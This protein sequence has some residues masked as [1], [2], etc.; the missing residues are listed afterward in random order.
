MKKENNI[1]KRLKTTKRDWIVF[2]ISALIAVFSVFYL[3]YFT[4]ILSEISHYLD[5]G[6]KTVIIFAWGVA[7]NRTAVLLLSV[8]SR[9]DKRTETIHLMFVSFIKYLIAII[10]IIILL[11]VWLGEEYV[12][13]IL[14]GIGVLALIIGLG[15]QSLINDILAGLFLVF[16]NHIN[17]GDV[18]SI[19]SWRGTVKEIGIRT[20]VLVDVSGNEKII[21]NSSITEFINLTTELSVAAVDI[22][23][24]YSIPIDRLEKVIND[25]LPKAKES[26]PKIVEGPT[27]LGVSDLADSAVYIK[28]IAKVKEE[29][30]FGVQRDLLRFFKITFD[31]NNITIPF[32]QVTISQRND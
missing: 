26:I 12:S 24:D 32:N 21:S 1:H 25:A 5:A 6:V 8:N 28:I 2:S 18:I 10:T 16:E 19:A 15:A 31:E 29:D 4:E 27:Y 22:G 14:T 17:V 13:S 11:V 3:I 30:R 20:T 7:L 23:V 9:G